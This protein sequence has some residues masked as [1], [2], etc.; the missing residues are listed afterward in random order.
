MNL[1]SV[2]KYIKWGNEYLENS[3]K[4]ADS[5]K[6]NRDW[7]CVQMTRAKMMLESAL[8]RLDDELRI[9]LSQDDT[10]ALDRAGKD[11]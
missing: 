6:E 5:T 10:I 1:Y 8:S 3:E 9:A 2:K 11:R 4:I 7:R